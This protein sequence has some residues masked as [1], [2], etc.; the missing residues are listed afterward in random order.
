MRSR[1]E[2]ERLVDLL[3]KV[4]EVFWFLRRMEPAVHFERTRG[5]GEDG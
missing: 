4:S 5:G 3:S 2:V 1:E